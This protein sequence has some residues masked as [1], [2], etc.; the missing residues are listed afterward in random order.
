M[1]F[2]QAKVMAEKCMKKPFIFMTRKRV[3][4]LSTL[5]VSAEKYALSEFEKSE[6][7]NVCPICGKGKPF[8]QR[9]LVG[10]NAGNCISTSYELYCDFCHYSPSAESVSTIEEA[11]SNWDAAVKRIE[12][13]KVNAKN[14]EFNQEERKREK[15]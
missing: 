7:K 14:A 6:N 1:N 2:S 10:D 15:K 4:M 9:L 13:A 5:I 3:H 8:V 11:V 12:Q